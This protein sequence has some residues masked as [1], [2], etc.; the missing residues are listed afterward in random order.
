MMRA[1]V[2]QCSAELSKVAPLGSNS[3]VVIGWSTA[4]SRCVGGT[5]GRTQ[6]NLCNRFTCE[7]VE[8]EI[9]LRELG[10]SS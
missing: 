9:K 2:P 5:S 7:I 6:A 3:L 10:K 1:I 4:R 8:A